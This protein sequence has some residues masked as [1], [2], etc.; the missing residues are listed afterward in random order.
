MESLRQ[1]ALQRELDR[2]EAQ[3]REHSMTA[4]K[5]AAELEAAEQLCVI[6]NAGMHEAAGLRPTMV[7]YGTGDAWV[8]IYTHGRA[9]N[10]LQR[11]AEADLEWEEVGDWGSEASKELKFAGFD[12]ASVIVESTALANYLASIAIE[13]AA[14]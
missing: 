6:I 10:V 14:A 7:Y 13:K 2:I 4:I 11:V 12:G 9:A 8:A 1:Q 5:Y 3:A